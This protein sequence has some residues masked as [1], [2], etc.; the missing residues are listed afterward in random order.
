MKTGEYIVI[1][2]GIVHELG[3]KQ[4]IDGPNRAISEHLANHSNCIVDRNLCDYFGQ[5][6][7]WSTNGYLQYL[8]DSE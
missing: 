7:T 6:F 8:S 2:D 3:L 5:N 4:Y 1:E